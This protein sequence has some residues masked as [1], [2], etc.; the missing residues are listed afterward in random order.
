MTTQIEPPDPCHTRP[1]DPGFVSYAVRVPPATELDLSTPHPTAALYPSLRRAAPNSFLSD[2][3][4]LGPQ[5]CR[6]VA[7]FFATLND[8]CLADIHQAAAVHM[9]MMGAPKQQRDD[10]EHSSNCPS[11]R[12]RVLV[13]D[14]GTRNYQ[15]HEHPDQ[16]SHFLEYNLVAVPHHGGSRLAD[17]RGIDR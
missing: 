17:S 1:K 6:G 14:A 4:L 3:R 8:A 9:P 15:L 12:C 11:G 13:G 5:F 7:H 10:V 16:F 2:L